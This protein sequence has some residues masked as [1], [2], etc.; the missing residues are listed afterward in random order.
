MFVKNEGDFFKHLYK[1]TKE[2][3]TL[4]KLFEHNLVSS[5]K[6]AELVTALRTSSRIVNKDSHDVLA[7]DGTKI[8]VTCI[9]PR[10]NSGGR[11]Y[12]ASKPVRTKQGSD[13]VVYVNEPLTRFMHV[14]YIMSY[15]VPAKELS[16]PFNHDGSLKENKYTKYLVT[17]TQY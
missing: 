11:K 13:L 2:P 6:L 4:E 7:P 8:E 15:D 5:A 3:L 10:V 17:S 9:T 12:S 1:F 16:I 14:Y